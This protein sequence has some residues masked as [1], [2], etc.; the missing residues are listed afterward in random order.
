MNRRDFIK[1]TAA[2]AAVPTIA[3]MKSLNVQPLGVAYGGQVVLIQLNDGAPGGGINYTVPPDWSLEVLNIA[4]LL[5]T[6]AAVA[7]RNAFVVA[8]LQ[9][10]IYMTVN[11]A[12]ALTA[13]NTWTVNFNRAIAS[14]LISGTVANINLPE[15]FLVP[16]TALTIAAGNIQAADQ[17]TAVRILALVWPV[18]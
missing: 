2:A 17:I 9:G 1:G 15:V 18:S 7:N 16:G 5:T 12:L 13:S 10:A 3:S 14:N 4:F 8:T 6:S 11:S